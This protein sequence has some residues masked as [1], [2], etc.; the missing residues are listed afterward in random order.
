[1]NEKDTR[2]TTPGFLLTINT[3]RSNT[4]ISML[5]EHQQWASDVFV[6]GLIGFSKN[7]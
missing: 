2:F 5:T 4:G 6:G 3:N 7:N 1:L